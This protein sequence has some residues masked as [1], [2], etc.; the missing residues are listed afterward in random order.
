MA[1]K[2]LSSLVSNYLTDLF[3]ELSNDT[4]IFTRS[5]ETNIRMALQ[6][7]ILKAALHIQRFEHAGAAPRLV[8]SAAIESDRDGS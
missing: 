7:T 8:P 3:E 5:I 2:S 1:D 6:R 4:N